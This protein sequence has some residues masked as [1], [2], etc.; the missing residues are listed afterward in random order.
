[1]PSARVGGRCHGETGG[2]QCLKNSGDVVAGACFHYGRAAARREQGDGN[3]S[4]ESAL[5]RHR[6]PLGLV[7]L[8]QGWITHSQLRKALEAHRENGTGRIGDWLI[9]ECGLEAEQITRGLS[10]QWGCPVLPV[11]G[12]SPE[13]MVLVMPQLFTTPRLHS[14]L[15]E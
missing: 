10:V 1:M 2:G 9:S 14:L 7:L 8:A 4:T 15:N 6:V 12:F 13:K 3:G 5:H 11:E